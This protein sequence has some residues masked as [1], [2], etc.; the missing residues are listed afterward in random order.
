M[1]MH[2]Y[3]SATSGGLVATRRKCAAMA[4]RVLLGRAPWGKDARVRARVG[5]RHGF[6]VAAAES[7]EVDGR[8][9]VGELQAWTAPVHIVFARTQ[10]IENGVGEIQRRALVRMLCEKQMAE[11]ERAKER[12]SDR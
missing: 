12:K 3:E 4:T 2:L 5:L 9:L 1:P 11:R 7:R 6:V 8:H 10:A